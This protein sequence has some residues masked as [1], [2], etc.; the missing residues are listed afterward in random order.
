MR[1][2]VNSAARKVGLSI[3][4]DVSVAAS[5]VDEMGELHRIFAQRR[6]ESAPS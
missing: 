4:S 2:K 1:A 6:A 5:A 3:P